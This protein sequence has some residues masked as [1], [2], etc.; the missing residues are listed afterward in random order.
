MY[1]L[2]TL[3]PLD[4]SLDQKSRDIIAKFPAEIRRVQKAI[5]N[6]PSPSGMSLDEY[7]GLKSQL[8]GYLAEMSILPVYTTSFSSSIGATSSGWDL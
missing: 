1:T 6:F 2:Q 3:P 5:E 7:Q 4:V 8:D